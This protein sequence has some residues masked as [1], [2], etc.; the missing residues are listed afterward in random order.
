MAMAALDFWNG[1]ALI[2]FCIISVYVGLRIMS[3]YFKYRQ[4]QL[5]IVGLTWICLVD[6]WYP[7]SISFIMF[8]LTG[9]ILTREAYFVIGN[10][11]IPI[12]LV[13]WVTAF[14]ELSMKKG[15]KIIITIAIIIAISFYCVFFYLILTDPSSV[16]YLKGI[17][18]VQYSLP[19]VIYYNIIIIFFLIT[20][21]I[22]AIKSIKAENPEISLK[23]KFLL[24]AFIFFVIGASMDTMVP[25]NFITLSI[26]RSLEILSALA[27]YCGFILPKWVK[28]I[29]LKQ[30]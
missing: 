11:L 21:L 25:L 12:G 13:C 26:Y 29:F 3:K 5:I 2:T 20:G 23:G 1:M 15:Q 18:D 10:V 17:T 16:G 9:Q 22:F 6:S 4:W 27:F 7:G 14:A 30:E 24:I 28:K 19:I 8:L